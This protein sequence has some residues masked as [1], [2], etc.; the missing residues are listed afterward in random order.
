MT[1]RFAPLLFPLL[2][3]AAGCS[4]GQG[5]GQVKSDVACGPTGCSGGLFV[6]DCWGSPVD[7]TH[8]QGAPYDLGSDLF[9]AANPYAADPNHLALQIR[10]QR[11]TDLTEVSDGLAVLVDDVNPIRAAIQAAAGARFPTREPP[12]REPPTAGASD[13]GAS[14]AGPG[15]RLAVRR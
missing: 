10:V 2:A 15:N 7:A 11:G 14:D 3:F 5:T 6:H 13:A 1:S 8:A 4:I 12:T 9:F